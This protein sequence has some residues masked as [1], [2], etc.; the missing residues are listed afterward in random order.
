M[1]PA[2]ELMYLT[3][4]FFSQNVCG[5]FPGTLHNFFSS[6]LSDMLLLTDF[7]TVMQL[8]Q[9]PVLSDRPSDVLIKPSFKASEQEFITIGAFDFTSE[10]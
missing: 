5:S 1:D 10:A 8:K 7:N 6:C 9:S 3:Y 4:F 2:I